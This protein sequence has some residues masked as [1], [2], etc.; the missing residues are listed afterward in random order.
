M[1]MT[2]GKIPL[3]FKMMTF[4]KGRL[5][6]SMLG[7]AFS[8]II[9]FM[10][11]GFFN[12]INDSQANLPPFLKADL[13]MMEDHRYSMLVMNTFRRIRL[14][15]ALAFDEVVEA[16]PI[17]E[18]N[19]VIVNNEDRRVRAIHILAFPPEKTSP[20]AMPGLEKYLEPLRIKGN[21]VFDRLSR[22]IYGDIKP[23]SQITLNGRS[24][25]VVGAVEIGPNLKLDGYLIMGDTTLEERVIDKIHMGLLRVKPGTDLNAL[26]QKLLAALPKDIIIM[27]PE[28]ARVRE[29]D[30]TIEKTPTGAVFGAGVIIGFFIGV[31]IC[32]QILFN[33][34]TDQMPQYATMKAVGFSKRFL[35]GLVMKQALFLAVFGF[36][37]GLLG[38]Y[39]LYG[40]IQR[41][42]QI[43]MI[44]T[45]ARSLFIFLLTVFMCAV[46]GLLA[47]RKVLKADPAELY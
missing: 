18:D 1:A 11:V 28:E 33:E 35:I 46:A 41:F 10:E 30:F 37:P 39:V 31:I 14:Q 7:I 5:I 9:M 20:F 47:V 25:N 40:L 12:G 36:I 29:V 26:K 42:T 45:P 19:G 4:R 23:G 34:I 13:V 24:H 3:A 15:Q 22:D 6:M 8:V 16:I 38:G 2:G 32:Y 21:V 27:T 17:Y 44:M 43:L